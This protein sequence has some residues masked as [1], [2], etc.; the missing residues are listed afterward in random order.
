MERTFAIIKPDAVAAKNAGKIIDMIEAAGF[1][2]VGMHKINMSQEQANELYKEHSARSFFGEM[3]A[4]M[5]ASPIIILALEKENAVLAWRDL[6]GA[7][8]PKDAAAGTVRALYGANIGANAAHG[9]D[10]LASAARE[11][12]IFFPAL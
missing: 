11:L 5:M 9:S 2:I 4:A 3:V 7:T 1:N 8:N 10:S 12:A 6:M